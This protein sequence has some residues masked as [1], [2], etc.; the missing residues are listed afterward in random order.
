[1]AERETNL[2]CRPTL[3]AESKSIEFVEADNKVAAAKR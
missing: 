3:C 2:L 1:M